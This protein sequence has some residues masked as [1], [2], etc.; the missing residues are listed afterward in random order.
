MKK[1][2][3][4][5]CGTVF[6]YSPREASETGEKSGR[7]CRR[8]KRGDELTI[9][10]AAELVKSRRHQDGIREFLDADT[11]LAPMPGHAPRRPGDQWISFLLARALAE[12]RLAMAHSRNAS[13]RRPQERVFAKR[14]RASPAAGTRKG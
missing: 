10:P 14:V 13:G 8:L 5:L 12:R 9:G 2:S 1:F 4:V 6:A 7:L 11:T 3:E